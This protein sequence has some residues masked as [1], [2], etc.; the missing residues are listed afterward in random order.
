MTEFA[1]ALRAA[2]TPEDLLSIT[3]PHIGKVEKGKALPVL[4]GIVT[5]RNRK[6]E[7]IEAISRGHSETVALHVEPRRFLLSIGKSFVLLTLQDQRGRHPVIQ[8]SWKRV[9]RLSGSGFTAFLGVEDTYI[10]ANELQWIHRYRRQ[11][12]FDELSAFDENGQ[13]ALRIVMETF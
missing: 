12:E 10:D 4:F 6:I 2:R 7:L 9:K 5:A 8:K 11:G 3:H 13:E 1:Q